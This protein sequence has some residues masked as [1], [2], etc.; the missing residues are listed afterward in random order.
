MICCICNN[1]IPTSMG[2]ANG[3]NAEPVESGRCCDICNDT[4]VIPARI[5]ALTVD[6]LIDFMGRDDLEAEALEARAEALEANRT[7]AK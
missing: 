2:W 6:R 3:H 5:S 7:N 4:V 1:D